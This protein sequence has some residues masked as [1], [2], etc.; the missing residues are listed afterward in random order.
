MADRA[1]EPVGETTRRVT[2]VITGSEGFGVRTVLLT[3]YRHAKQGGTNFSYLAS[4][5]GDCAKAL[6]AA[7]ASVRIIGGQIAPARPGH[8]VLF[9]LFWLFRLPRLYRA[10]A[11]IRRILRETPSE[12]LYTHSFYSLAIGRLAAR[13]LP[14]RVICHMHRDLDQT[15]LGGMQRI[16]VSL[17]LAA[18]ADRLVAISDFVAASVWGPARRKVCRVDNAVDV[19]GIIAAV[20]G[21][22]KIPRRIV[23]VGR[24]Q[25]RKK[26]QVAI[27]AIKILRERGIE[28]DL[29]M[30]G[31][32][33]RA[34]GR[35]ERTLRDL[36][37]ALDLADRVRFA[38]V[39][40][41]P[42]RRVAA[43]I[44]C[45]S[46]A[47][48]EPFGL[49]VIE[50]AA[51]GTAVVAADAGATAEL[52]EDRKTGL[53]FRADDPIALADALEDILR[54]NALAASLTETARRRVLERYDI[55]EHLRALR[56][57]FDAALVQP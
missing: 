54:H 27:R 12:I 32:R 10:Y 19:R 39:V 15:R 36:I 38:G 13:G 53:L 25:A 7:G 45:V 43:A 21:V 41:P 26:Q 46:C 48:R 5:D 34:S 51:C 6:R 30:I 50:A 11:G 37:N 44:A 28:C 4:Q 49:A 31:G 24:L 3:Q 29:E 55:P 56:R 9:P 8:I 14:C 40:S 42:Y 23:I 22:A 1:G 47:T 17:A 18:S 20:H 33:G 52:I 57:C 16:L 2:V 35:H